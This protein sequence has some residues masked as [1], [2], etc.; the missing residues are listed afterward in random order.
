MLGVHTYTY[1][2]TVILYIV[3]AVMFTGIYFLLCTS[4]TQN[5][6][7]YKYF[8]TY[9]KKMVQILLM[10]TVIIITKFLSMYVQL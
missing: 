2:R 8:H 4:S 9:A 10:C 1:T 5:I 6:G 3:W 7:Y